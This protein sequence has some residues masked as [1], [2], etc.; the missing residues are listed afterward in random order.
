MVASA[1]V[2]DDRRGPRF[3][4]FVTGTDLSCMVGRAVACVVAV[5]DG[6]QN[7]NRAQTTSP[8]HRYCEVE[9]T[10]KDRTSGAVNIHQGA[11]TRVP[12][13]YAGLRVACAR[14]LRKT[15]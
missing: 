10:C 5:V 14:L 15:M 3:P 4:D 11:L 1:A 7:Y 6:V 9:S 12:A 8:A 13:P 2:G